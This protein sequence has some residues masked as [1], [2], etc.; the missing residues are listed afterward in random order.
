MLHSDSGDL[1]NGQKYST[2]S[3]DAVDWPQDEDGSW[4]LDPGLAIYLN[5]KFG[6]KMNGKVATLSDSDTWAKNSKDVW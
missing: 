4:R 5:R 2:D 3:N 6:K 1:E